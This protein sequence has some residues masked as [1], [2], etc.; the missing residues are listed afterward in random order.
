MPVPLFPFFSC[1]M[2]HRRWRERDDLLVDSGVVFRGYHRNFEELELGL[3]MFDHSE[4]GTAFSL[5]VGEF[6]DLYD[7]P[8]FGERATGSGACPRH[9]LYADDLR[10]CPARCECAWVRELLCVVSAWPKAGSI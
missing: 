4:C 2:C 1:P 5:E 9:C 3:F 8:V 6:R 10:S 7:G